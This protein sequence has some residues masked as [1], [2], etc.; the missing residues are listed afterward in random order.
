MTF[1]P[2]DSTDYT[3]AT[4]TATINVDQATPTINWTNPA[5]IT[6]GTSL[7]STQLDATASWIVG[8]VTRMVSG[9]FDYTPGKGTI[10]P[11]GSG[12]V[13]SVLFTPSATN[14]YVIAAW[15]WP[16]STSIRPRP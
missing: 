6:Y 10:L 14:D 1:T 8:G 15:H 12:Q 9:A 7:S 11:G 4:G 2:N 3:T 16:R 13:L 5:D